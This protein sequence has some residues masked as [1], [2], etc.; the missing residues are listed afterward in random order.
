MRGSSYS[1]SHESVAGYAQQ[2]TEQKGDIPQH[3][4]MYIDYRCMGRDME[5]GGDIFTIETG[6]QEVHIFWSH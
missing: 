2:L 1:G 3:L 5:L 6:Y 4:E